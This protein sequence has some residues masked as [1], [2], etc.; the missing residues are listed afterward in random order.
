MMNVSRKVVL[1][2]FMIGTF[3][4]GMTE[5]VVTGLLTQFARDLDVEIAATGLLLSV[6]ALSVTIFGPIV[7]LL[8]LKFSPK[9]LM[10]LLIIVFIGSNV[11]AALAPN[12]ET[13]LLSRLLSATMHAPFF[14]LAMSLAMAISPPHKKTGSIAAVNGGLTI[15]VML[16][17]PF[18]SFIGATLDWRLVFWIIASLGLITLIGLFFVT[19]NY[20][21]KEIPKVRNELS[22]FKN[23]NVLMV[24]FIIVFGFSGVFT[25]YTFMEPM[26]REIT[27]FGALG[28]TISMFLFGLGA[29]IGN[30]TSGTV[31][32]NMLTRRIIMTMALLGVILAAFTF[33]L[34]NP[35]FAYIASFLFGAG[36]FGT[37][38]ILNSKII[39]AAI[40]APALSGTLA[41]SVFNLA[42]SIGATLGSLLLSTGLGY[43]GITFVAAAMILFGSLSMLAGSRFEDKHLFDT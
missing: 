38:P 18:G 16:G 3:A 36:T 4:I 20:R 23:K 12:F 10:L 33:M 42:N 34:Q 6:Y 9:V 1:T 7:R 5:Y 32:P 15:A 26:L 39:F 31:Q 40:E 8:T 37:T 22:V 13:L 11:V 17:V 29:V 35:L 24:I 43:T 25:A 21:P 19:P 41:A 28:I 30:F 27:G 2:V 14:G